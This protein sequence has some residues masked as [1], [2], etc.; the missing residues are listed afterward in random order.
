[1]AKTPRL[2]CVYSEMKNGDYFT[3]LFRLVLSYHVKPPLPFEVVARPSDA[4]IILF[5]E[6]DSIQTTEFVEGKSYAILTK[7]PRRKT[8]NNI[9]LIH[10][11]S[12]ITD[13]SSLIQRIQEE[14]DKT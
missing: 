14:I 5:S 8:A 13:F 11:T 4:D 12:M 2:V 7:T 3:R 6:D 10:I 1:M 9:T